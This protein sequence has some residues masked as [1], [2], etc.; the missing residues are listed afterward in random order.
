M[1]KY[2]I[3]VIL[4]AVPFVLALQTTNSG[5]NI[6]PIC[7]VNPKCAWTLVAS[8]ADP[9]TSFG[10]DDRSFTDIVTTATDRRGKTTYSAQ[11]SVDSDPNWVVWKVPTDART[12]Q[13]CAIVDADGEDAVVEIWGCAGPK[14][15][16][17]N[18]LADSFILGT[19]ITVK[20]GTQVG[21]DSDV[22]CDTATVSN[23]TLTAVAEDSG[24]NRI[25]TVTINI[26]G[27][28]AIAFIGTTVDTNCDILARWG[29]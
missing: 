13:F 10:V 27:L 12:V 20:G 3:L 17:T 24:N 23:S 15:L 8:L 22:Y 25:A 19:V 11:T 29:N 28:D 1:K 26:E 2:S 7:V 21:P 14:I 6:T 5:E 4:L 9:N 16:G 18:S